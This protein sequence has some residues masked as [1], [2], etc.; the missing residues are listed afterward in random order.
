MDYF[1]IG[2]AN[3]A[4]NSQKHKSTIPK[5]SLKF[6]NADKVGGFAV[7]S[8]NKTAMSVTMMS[9]DNKELHQRVLRPR[10]V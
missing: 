7:M 5:D 2:P 9:G 4:E 8:V 3:F 6:F 10:N 1:V